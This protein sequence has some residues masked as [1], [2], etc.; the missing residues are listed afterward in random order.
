MPV[1]IHPHALQRA[2]ERGADD[3]EIK[4]TVK[5][6][7]E[8]PVKFGRTGFRKNF[9]YNNKWNG[10]YYATKQIECYCVKELNK[11]LVITILVKY[12]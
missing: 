1:D 11:W 2:K 4:D 9:L 6:G 10:K 7:E 3:E 8:F 12:F 5:S